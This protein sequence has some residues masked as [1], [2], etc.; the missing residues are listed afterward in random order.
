MV[1]HFVCANYKEL[2][3]PFTLDFL[4]SVKRLINDLKPRSW[5][6]PYDRV[7]VSL[8]IHLTALSTQHVSAQPS[9][10][11]W[12]VLRVG[13]VA[14]AGV[15]RCPPTQRGVSCVMERQTAH[16]RAPGWWHHIISNPVSLET[17][18]HE[19]KYCWVMQG[20]SCLCTISFLF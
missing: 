7:P 11:C 14:A 18:T 17:N 15:K 1:K 19:T 16:V 8:L 12:E 4:S 3:S 9:G 6:V 2:C 10:K 5:P 20:S 13:G